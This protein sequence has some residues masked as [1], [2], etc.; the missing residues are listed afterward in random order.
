VLLGCEARSPD[1]LFRLPV[2]RK[3]SLFPILPMA[4][5]RLRN[6]GKLCGLLW[7]RH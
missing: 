7:S 2:V 6:L 1:W 3:G 4:R 5:P